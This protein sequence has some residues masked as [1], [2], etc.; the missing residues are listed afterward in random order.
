[1]NRKHCISYLLFLARSVA[2]QAEEERAGLLGGVGAVDGVNSFLIRIHKN[3]TGSS[4]LP[5]VPRQI[6]RA[7]SQRT[8][9]W[10][11]SWL[12]GR[13]RWRTLTLS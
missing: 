5:A 7:A 12:R 10:S 9:R 8:V 4:F 1:M 13:G 11:S 2:Q 6:C 3:E